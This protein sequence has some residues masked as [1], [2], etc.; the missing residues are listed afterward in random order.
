MKIIISK[1]SN[2]KKWLSFYGNKDHYLV[3]INQALKS[4][5]I[6]WLNTSNLSLK[7]LECNKVVIYSF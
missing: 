2:H 5:Q 3:E 1:K 7:K 6:I 4:Y